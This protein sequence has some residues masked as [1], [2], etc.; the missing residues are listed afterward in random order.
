MEGM[1]RDLW[2]VSV[3]NPQHYKTMKEV[4]ER[5]A[6]SL[7]PTEPWAGGRWKSIVKGDKR[8]A[9]IYETADPGKFPDDVGRPSVVPEFRPA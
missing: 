2:S 9:V 5:T 1:R 4:F 8:P 6:L 3:D 7:I